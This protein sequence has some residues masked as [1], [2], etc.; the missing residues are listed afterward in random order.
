MCNCGCL[1]FMHSN[2]IA[3]SSFVTMF[4][5]AKMDKSLCMSMVILV[6]SF[7]GQKLLHDARWIKYINTNLRVT[8]QNNTISK[9]FHAWRM[10]P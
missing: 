6:A 4:V 8:C 7:L 5:P 1:V 9:L 3:T 2:F 10:F